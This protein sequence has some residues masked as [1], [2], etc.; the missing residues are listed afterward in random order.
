MTAGSVAESDPAE[1]SEA[2]ASDETVAGRRQLQERNREETVTR[3]RQRRIEAEGRQGGGR[4]ETVPDQG[5]A[6]PLH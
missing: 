4:E 3:R 2:D 1:A 6:L 5:N